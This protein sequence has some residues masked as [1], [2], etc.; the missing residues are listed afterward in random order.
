MW[1]FPPFSRPIFPNVPHRSVS[2]NSLP[3]CRAFSRRPGATG[4]RWC[5]V[6][7]RP[8]RGARLQCSVPVCFRRSSVPPALVPSAPAFPSPF[9]AV[10][11]SHSAEIE[12]V[13]LFQHVK[14][15]Q[16]GGPRGPPGSHGRG[17]SRM[18]G[19]LGVFLLGRPR[20]RLDSEQPGPPWG[21]GTGPSMVRRGHSST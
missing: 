4:S 8:Q 12:P 15:R 19:F 2:V 9:R 1:L 13:E 5:A 17:L 7:C 10:S 18:L 6:P 16:R 11:L 21:N 20:S 3:T 14:M